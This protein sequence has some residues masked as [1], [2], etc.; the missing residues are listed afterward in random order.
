MALN[1]NPYLYFDGQ[2]E[3]AFR[4][5]EKCLAG[6]ITF[7]MKNG[8]TGSEC[9][10]QHEVSALSGRDD[11]WIRAVPRRPQRM[12]RRLGHRSSLDLRAVCLL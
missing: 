6:K 8:R 4:F 10:G 7:M 1:L 2:C 11:S 12:P 9:G 5:Y 3:E